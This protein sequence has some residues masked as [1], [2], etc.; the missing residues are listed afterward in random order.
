MINTRNQQYKTKNEIMFIKES[1]THREKIIL[2]TIFSNKLL[3]LP[4]INNNNICL[5]DR[6]QLTVTNKKS[7]E[8]FKPK[9]DKKARVKLEL[10]NNNNAINIK[11]LSLNQKSSNDNILLLL[12]QIKEKNKN[13]KY[14][15]ILPE[16][17]S[18]DSFIKNNLLLLNKYYYK[19]NDNKKEKNTQFKTNNFSQT[20]KKL[21]TIFINEPNISYNNINSIKNYT[22]NKNHENNYYP[23]LKT[24][25]NKNEK[26]N[27]QKFIIHNI[28]FEWMMD[29]MNQKYLDD[30]INLNKNE[31]LNQS[32]DLSVNILNKSMKIIRKKYK[33]IK[34]AELQRKTY[35]NHDKSDISKDKEKEKEIK[36]KFFGSLKRYKLINIENMDTKSIN[37]STYHN[38]LETLSKDNYKNNLKNI[39]NYNTN[40]INIQKEQ[41]EKE[42]RK[43]L[44]LEKI[45]NFLGRFLRRLLNKNHPNESNKNIKNNEPSKFNEYKE[46]ISFN[47][48]NRYINTKKNEEKEKEK[49]KDEI[50]S[51]L[52]P[53][54]KA[55]KSV[56]IERK[57]NIS[58]LNDKIK[59]KELNQNNKFRGKPKILEYKWKKPNKINNN[60]DLIQLNKDNIEND[61]NKNFY[62]VVL[63]SNPEKIIIGNNTIKSVRKNIIDDLKSQDKNNITK[64][65][66]YNKS[67]KPKNLYK[68]T[69]LKNSDSN[70]I[71][72]KNSSFEKDVNNNNFN[73]NII[74]KSG[75]GDNHNIYYKNFDNNNLNNIIQGNIQNNINNNRNNNIINSNGDYKLKANDIKLD[76]NNMNIKG[77]GTNI[78]GNFDS[79]AKINYYYRN[80]K[81]GDIF[82]MINYTSSNNTN[83]EKI[84][85]NKNIKN[86]MNN[87]IRNNIELQTTKKENIKEEYGYNKNKTGNDNDKNNNIIT[88]RK[89]EIKS[90]YIKESKDKNN[91]NNENI[92]IASKN[93]KDNDSQNISINQ[94]KNKEDVIHKNSDDKNKNNFSSKIMKSEENKNITKENNKSKNMKKRYSI[95]IGN[96]N[97]E[98][99]NK[100]KRR[101]SAF[102][103]P[104]V[105]DNIKA[106]NNI[107]NNNDNLNTKNENNKDKKEKIEN[108]L[109]TDKIEISEKDKAEIEQK[110]KELLEN[111]KNDLDLEQILFHKTSKKKSRR[112]SRRKSKIEN[113]EEESE[114]DSDSEIEFVKVKKRRRSTLRRNSFLNNLL[115]PDEIFGKQIDNKN[116]TNNL[117]EEDMDKLLIYSSKLH[118]LS[119]LDPSLKTDEIIKLEKE[120]KDK[121]NEIIGKYVMKQKYKDLLKHKDIKIN[122][123]KLKILMEA[124]NEDDDEY[125]Y[126]IK[127]KEKKKKEN[128]INSYIPTKIESS[129]EESSESEIIAKK[130]SSKKLIYDNSY[131]FKKDKEDSDIAIRP[132]VLAILRN[133]TGSNNINNNNNSEINEHMSSITSRK[134]KF[135]N[136]NSRRGSI[137]K[138]KQ[139]K[140]KKKPIDKYKISLFSDVIVE[141]K[142]KKEEVETQEDKHEK[143]LEKK[144][145][146]FFE[147]IQRIKKRGGNIDIYDFLKTEEIKDNEKISRLIDFSENM[148]NIRKK[149]KN[150]YLKFNYLSPIQFKTKK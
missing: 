35:M 26:N 101:S 20:P 144:I 24:E 64:N 129:E 86:I 80:D 65:M 71:I 92:K 40:Y 116:D 112:K 135:I 134:K 67:Y 122:R 109:N 62:N 131:L 88:E 142:E 46:D 130:I 102:I 105:L 93:S 59:L 41:F 81:N 95:S 34:S 69:F 140:I 132:E 78:K 52:I 97:F 48:N 108:N 99:K 149:E 77:K 68:T 53:D 120:I 79:K 136:Y 89:D 7:L 137:S 145:K 107:I 73:N 50:M 23:A 128:K 29:K 57:L 127:K 147:K 111:I 123:K 56:K 83:N 126:I 11:Y 4:I 47:Y 21:N 72:S 38:L 1:H 44:S 75:G 15:E 12:K 33:K 19:I 141:T 8:G 36:K 16:E 84:D 22:N 121:Y 94:N 146:M 87:N 10:K 76:E 39:Y 18:N 27:K 13:K 117:N 133:T 45:D 143:A 115:D 28:F 31:K 30:F 118:K 14:N 60:N 100:N 58:V 106:N 139:R 49:E 2:K 9:E 119:E 3:S 42:R 104:E 51:V 85:K 37:K 124:N 150:S 61:I 98:N 138:F 113:Q 91:M 5:S 54:Y 148:S 6:N 32:F 125:E 110:Q 55:N 66:N 63:I 82:D 103:S 43:I 74:N 90:N 96:K 17:L 114:N 70:K 25:N